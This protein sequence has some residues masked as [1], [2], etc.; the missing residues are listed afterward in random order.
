MSQTNPAPDTRK[1]CGCGTTKDA[2]GYCDGSHA[3]LPPKDTRKKCGCG[4][5]KD[6][7]GYC[8]GSHAKKS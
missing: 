1:K 6:A 4:H 7:Q 8:D 5:T 2:Q 3:K